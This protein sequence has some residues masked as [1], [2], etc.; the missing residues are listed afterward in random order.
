MLNPPG[1][2][3]SHCHLDSVRICGDGCVEKIRLVGTI[4]AIT[5]GHAGVDPET[6][7]RATNAKFET[8]FAYVEDELARR[9]KGPQQASLDEMDALWNEAKSRA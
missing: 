1:L 7:L 8:R 2:E 3:L 4:L 9:G 5:R 6:A